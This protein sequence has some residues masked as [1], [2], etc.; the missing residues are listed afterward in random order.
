MCSATACPGTT[1][2][3]STAVAAVISQGEYGFGVINATTNAANP[4]ATS[5]DE[6]ENATPNRDAVSCTLSTSAGSE[7]DELFIWVPKFTLNSLRVALE[8]LS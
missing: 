3:T 1:T 5:P 6:I 4:P 7:F 2:L 8:G